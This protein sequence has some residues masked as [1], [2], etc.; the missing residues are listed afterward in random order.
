V[1]RKNWLF[2]GSDEGAERACILYSLIASCKLHGVNPFDYLRDVLVRVGDHPARDA[3]HSVP[4][5]GRSQPRTS[6]LR[7]LL[8]RRAE[9][10]PLTSSILP[11][12][13]T[14]SQGALHRTDTL[15]HTFRR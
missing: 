10:V 2:A 8:P 1:G 13:N 7:R 3:S 15:D 4:K 5:T 14:P 9:R 12:T 11:H 6:T